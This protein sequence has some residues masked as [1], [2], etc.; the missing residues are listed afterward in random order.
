[1]L[2]DHM[3]VI[4]FPS[5]IIFR[6]IGRLAFPIFAFFIAEGVKH[7]SNKLKYFFRVFVLGVVCQLGY[8][9]SELMEYGRITGIYFNV[10]LTFSIGILICYAWQAAIKNKKHIALF[11]VIVIAAALVQVLKRFSYR[12][13]FGIEFDYGFM[14]MMLPLCAMIFEKK[15]QKFLL[16]GAGL[17]LLCLQFFDT[18]YQWLSLLTIPLLLLYNNKR[19]KA[20]LKY[21]FYIFYPVHIV[22][23]YGISFLI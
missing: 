6:C 9:A 20:N 1:M 22:V 18:P 11:I 10:L 8:M 23:L 12:L 17:V 5:Q 3:G 14:G 13:G 7:T 15:T 4:L 21:L 2:I 19:G 16:F